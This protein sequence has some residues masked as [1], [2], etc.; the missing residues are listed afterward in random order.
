MS[1]WIERERERIKNTRIV[2]FT[3]QEYTN[4]LNALEAAEIAL[5]HMQHERNCNWTI[6]LM[7]GEGRSQGGPGV[8]CNCGNQDA[9]RTLSTTLAHVQEMT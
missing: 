6:G 4:M 3:N 1:D 5:G 7:R 2:S 9:V 8:T